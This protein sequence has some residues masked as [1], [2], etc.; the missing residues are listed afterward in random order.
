MQNLMK[1][2]VAILAVAALSPLA[3]MAHE[4]EIHINPAFGSAAR[5]P[6]ATRTVVITPWT[7]YVNVDQGDVVTFQIDGN[8][9]TWQFDTLRPDTSF[10]LSAIVPAGFNARGV[11]VYVA[12]NPTYRN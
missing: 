7:K 8:A 12:P 3:A 5:T 1:K 10:N 11:R 6:E 4:G 9:F 2:V